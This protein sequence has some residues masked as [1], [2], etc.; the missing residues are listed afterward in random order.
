MREPPTGISTVFAPLTNFVWDGDEFVI[1][2]FG[3]IKPCSEISDIIRNQTSICDP[4]KKQAEEV[5]HWLTFTQRPNDALVPRERVNIFLLALWLAIPTKTNVRVRFEFQN[6]SAEPLVT[7]HHDRFHWTRGHPADRLETTHLEQAG[8]H[9]PSLRSVYLANKRLRN[10]LHLTFAGCISI[11]W[12]VAYICYSAAAES[13]LA[14]AKDRIGHRLSLAFACLTKREKEE[15]DAAY[16]EFLRLYYV[17]SDIMHG[18]AA[19]RTDYYKSQWELAKLTDTLRELWQ[20]VLASPVALEEL[21]RD[22]DYRREF[23]EHLQQG[24]RP[25]GQ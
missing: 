13:M 2:G 22:D 6:G 3:T 24:Y 1:E 7:C 18:R 16:R 23:F 15:R 11:H 9:V 14:Y 19:D 25:P 5:A 12:Q 4:E 17:R 10:A 21:E 8:S 20:A